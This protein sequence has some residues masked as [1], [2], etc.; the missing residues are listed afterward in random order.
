M[1]KR[2]ILFSFIFVASFVKAS[3]QPAQQPNNV[4]Q[5]F[6]PAYVRQPN[7]GPQMRT[8]NTTPPLIPGNAEDRAL[9]KLMRENR[10]AP[11][12]KAQRPA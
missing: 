4:G 6:V 12:R 7:A 2:S 1:N 10:K 11:N 9:R 8:G 5:N 3:Q